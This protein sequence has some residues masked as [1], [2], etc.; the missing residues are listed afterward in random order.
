MADEPQQTEGLYYSWQFPTWTSYFGDPSGPAVPTPG[1]SSYYGG[2]SQASSSILSFAAGPNSTG[3]HD[4]RFHNIPHDSSPEANGVPPHGVWPYGLDPSAAAHDPSGN[5][6]PPPSTA[7]AL[8]LVQ[9]APIGP[10]GPTVFDMMHA[11]PAPHKNLHDFD[12]VP[13]SGTLVPDNWLPH[14]FP[15]PGGSPPWDPSLDLLSH[16]QIDKFWQ[17]FYGA[18]PG[19]EPPYNGPLDWQIWFPDEMRA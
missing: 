4:E 11:A 10:H 17:D 5:N 14:S 3:S 7:T 13:Q 18:R 12:I 6:T 15:V 9:A 8:Q 2:S 1:D 19:A 16:D